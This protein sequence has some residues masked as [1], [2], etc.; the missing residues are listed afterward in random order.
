MKV[1]V[2]MSKYGFMYCLEGGRCFTYFPDSVTSIEHMKRYFVNGG[3]TSARGIFDEP[4]I[5]FVN[6]EGR[7]AKI[8]TVKPDKKIIVD[9][10]RQFLYDPSEVVPIEDKLNFFRDHATREQDI[11][12]DKLASDSERIKY[13]LSVST[14][15]TKAEYQKLIDESLTPDSIRTICSEN[16]KSFDPQLEADVIF[17]K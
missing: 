1:K 10:N 6:Q 9:F 2:R 5:Q 8:F 14:K 13:Y 4:S 11:E 12:A 15:E 3:H 17:E 7:P 16:A